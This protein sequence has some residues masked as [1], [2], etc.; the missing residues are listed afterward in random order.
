M[1]QLPIPAV[2]KDELLPLGRE[3]LV[4]AEEGHHIPLGHVGVPVARLHAGQKA[5]ELTLRG[6]RHFDLSQHSVTLFL[7][8][9]KYICNINGVDKIDGTFKLN[10]NRQISFV[11]VIK[12]R[13]QVSLHAVASS[14]DGLAA[15]GTAAVVQS[16]AAFLAEEVTKAALH[17]PRLMGHALKTNRTLWVLRL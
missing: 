3:P 2:I 13:L 12:E 15:A 1:Q 11:I 7:T 9:E 4:V 16:V 14:C 8:D 10:Y 17:Y 5:G 6:R